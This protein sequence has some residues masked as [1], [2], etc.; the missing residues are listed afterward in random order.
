MK[1]RIDWR[2]FW[3]GFFDAWGHPYTVVLV[4]TYAFTIWFYWWLQ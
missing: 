4:F 2:A 3:K 1:G